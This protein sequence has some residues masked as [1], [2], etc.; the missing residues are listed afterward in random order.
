MSKKRVYE[1]AKD[2]GVSNKEMVERVLALGVNIKNHMSTIDDDVIDRLLS[3]S[4]PEPPSL[5]KP[6]EEKPA[7]AAATEEADAE[8]AAIVEEGPETTTEIIV[9]NIENIYASPTKRLEVIRQKEQQ[10]TVRGAKTTFLKKRGGRRDKGSDDSG[11]AGAVAELPKAGKRTLRLSGPVTVKDISRE[12]N[13]KTSDIIMYLM[14]EMN[15]MSTLNQSLDVDVATLVAEH[16]DCSVEHVSS[17]LGEDV[18]VVIGEDGSDEL[19]ARPPV[20]TIMGHVDHGKTKLLDA[21]RKTNVVATE[22]G[23][24]TQHIGAYQIEHNGRK[25]TFLDTPGHASFTALR[26][27]G[28]KVTDLAVL[29]VA[30]DDGVMPQTIEAIDHARAANVPILVAV[31]KIDKPSANPDR[32]KQQL[33]DRGL[34]PEEWG[35]ETVYCA[36]SAK[37]QT[38]IQELIDMMFLVTDIA[39]L[40]A[41]PGRQAVGTIIEAQLDKGKGPAATVLV[42]N[43]TLHTGDILVV[44]L[45][46]GRVRSMENDRGEAMQE[47]GPSMPVKIFGL[48]SVPQ[49]GDR[50]FVLED[51]KT[52]REI[53]AKRRLKDREERMKSHS[54]ISLDDLFQRIKEGQLKEFKI[55]VKGDVQGS[56]EAITQSLKEIKHEEVRVHVIHSGVGDIRETDIMLAAASDAVILGFNVVV[57]PAAFGM[58]QREGVDIR[59]YDIIYKLTDDVKNAMAGMLAPEFVQEYAGRAEVRTMFQSSRVGLIAGCYVQDGEMTSNMIVKLKR[60]DKVIYEGKIGSLKRFKDNVK[61]V[62]QGYECGIVIDGFKEFEEGD[63]IEGYIMKEVKRKLI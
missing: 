18:P 55:I 17:E 12:L 33:S 40:K 8:A 32:V 6:A 9:E 31:N 46:Q 58:A 10:R 30:A 21:I 5:Q 47:A 41:N 29:V 45:T 54:R 38:N 26:A 37:M 51:E 59:L 57:N 52:A 4:T 53:V 42:Q 61:A 50:L 48:G 15:L 36:I 28:A 60:S 1:I 49:S 13:I 19:V 39:E 24:I 7:E 20:V 22:A 63:I 43:G 16:F 11:A 2:L 25:I 34:V 44:G 14:K 27:R 62:Q 23:G 3:P 56:I 35:G